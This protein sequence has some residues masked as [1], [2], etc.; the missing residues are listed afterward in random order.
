M[1]ESSYLHGQFRVGRQAQSMR[2]HQS[3]IGGILDGHLHGGEDLAMGGRL[4]DDLSV[5][6]TGLRL[7]AVGTGPRTESV[8]NLPDSR[9]REEHPASHPQSA[10]CTV[11]RTQSAVRAKLH[12]GTGRPFQASTA[13]T[14][15]TAAA[16]RAI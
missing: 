14:Y 12:R 4:S 8:D 16:S 15:A 13:D 3:G 11:Q 2:R 7:A 1:S 10:L 5:P 9:Q 6:A